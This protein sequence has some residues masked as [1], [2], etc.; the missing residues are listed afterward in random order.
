M[1]ICSLPRSSSACGLEEQLQH[2]GRGRLGSPYPC[3]VRLSRCG[4]LWE[5]HRTSERNPS[6]IGLTSG[7]TLPEF[8]VETLGGKVDIALFTPPPHPREGLLAGTSHHLASGG[9]FFPHTVLCCTQ[10]LPAFWRQG[11]EFR[12]INI[13]KKPLSVWLIS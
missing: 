1:S 11:L 8:V 12:S 2:G 6:V 5:E 3:W 13:D 10:V 7:G 4:Q 9:C